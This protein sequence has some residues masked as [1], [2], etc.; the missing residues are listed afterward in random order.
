MV[1]AT[2]VLQDPSFERNKKIQRI[3]EKFD[4]NGDGRLSKNEMA[5]LVVAVNPRVRFSDDQISSI[6]DEVFKTY[7]EFIEPEEGL[8][9][10]GLRRTY[11][12]GAGDVNRDFAALGLTLEEVEREDL[13]TE[14]ELDDSPD[15][16]LITL[17]ILTTPKYVFDSTQ[18]VLDDLELILTRHEKLSWGDKKILEPS[19]M[20]TR[21]LTVLRQNVDRELPDAAFEAHMYVG[22]GL[23]AKGLQDEAVISFKRAISFREKDVRGHFLCGS[24]LYSLG[25]V[26]EAKMEFETALGN[27]ES[28]PRSNSVILPQVHVNLGIALEAEGMLMNACYHYREAA[29]LNPQ[30]FRTLK[31]LGSALYALGDI[32]AAAEALEHAL[33]INPNYADAH[34]EL[35]TTLH[36]K[37][38]DIRARQEFEHAIQ[39]QPNHIQALYNLGGLY[40]SQGMYQ[41]AVEQY[42]EVLKLDPKSWKAEL[43][44]AVS[45]LGCGKGAEAE[46]GLQQALKMTNRVELYDALRQLKRVSKKAK[47]LPTE[48]RTVPSSTVGEEKFNF[49]AASS[50]V[51][52]ESL[53][54]MVDEK[55]SSPGELLTALDIWA[56]QKAT[57]LCR[58]P[59]SKL[60]EVFMTAKSNDGG[61][62]RTV[63]KP[64]LELIVRKL[65]DFL[66]PE[67][68][69]EAMKALNEKVISKLVDTG[70]VD[71][72]L[73]AASIALACS[74][75][76]EER[77]N[78]AFN[79]L[80]SRRNGDSDGISRGETEAFVE[81]LQAVYLAGFTPPSVPSRPVGGLFSQ[82]EFSNAIDTDMPIWRV[83]L[84]LEANDRMRHVKHACAVCSYTI[85]GLR[86]R[87]MQNK[88]DLCSYCFS[89]RK[90]PVK[91]TMK[92]YMFKEFSV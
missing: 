85:V 64:A 7:S 86:F 87:E 57:R 63:R 12:D 67:T 31:L 29:I 80:M 11:N 55:S 35:G 62:E 81:L 20:L 16:D 9:L 10:D 50:I 33:C 47:S 69:Q 26:Q 83:I 6:L 21:E 65:L 51:V 44:K 53:I 58:C 25:N 79:F 37:G 76:M 54:E 60:Q 17:E 91:L 30:H 8:S 45:L 49:G 39:L 48:T 88:F 90:I 13:Q 68:F 78:V 92:S 24:A 46:K 82:K 77:K 84:N 15:D 2:S 73:F 3:F 72:G 66:E 43:N 71:A 27:A 56:F 19:V 22:R 89:E 36:A 52:E 74:G 23:I 70:N 42:K 28:D 1:V 32:S 75:P 40:R 38:E 4:V 14:T 41:A 61:K 5:A 34:C 59:V 18:S